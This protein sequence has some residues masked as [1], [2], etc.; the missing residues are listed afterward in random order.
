[1]TGGSDFRSGWKK[2]RKMGSSN[3]SVRRWHWRFHPHGSKKTAK[4]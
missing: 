2:L 4:C 3:R 1:M